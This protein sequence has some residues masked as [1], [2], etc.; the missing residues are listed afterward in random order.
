M[1]LLQRLPDIFSGSLQPNKHQSADHSRRICVSRLPPHIAPEK[2]KSTESAVWRAGPRGEDS[3]VKSVP[4]NERGRR[5]GRLE[6]R[7]WPPRSRV[8]LEVGWE[9]Q[10]SR[11]VYGH[12]KTRRNTVRRRRRVRSKSVGP[13]TTRPARPRYGLASLLTFSSSSTA[14]R[15][16]A[17]APA[18]PTTLLYS[19]SPPSLPK[20]MKR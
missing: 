16:P 3:K 4:E 1:V 15:P 5:K 17:R 7:A 13:V 9:E 18:S 6:A 11:R 14:D 10:D 8:G 2:T 20:S 19:S 12:S